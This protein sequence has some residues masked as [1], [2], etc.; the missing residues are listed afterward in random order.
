KWAPYQTQIG[1]GIFTVDAILEGTTPLTHYEDDFLPVS[2]GLHSTTAS[3]R[4]LVNYQVDR[5]FIAA[6][7]QYIQRGDIT[8]DQNAY[9]T[10]QEIYSN[11]VYMPNQNNFLVS[12]GFRS[13]KLN[14]EAILSQT[15]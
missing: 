3:L 14:A 1:R 4:A 5:F 11:R 8:I 9:Y 12:A 6:A 15:T 2:I 7:G 13:L 10:T